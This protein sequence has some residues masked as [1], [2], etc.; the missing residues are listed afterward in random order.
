MYEQNKGFFI[1]W[2]KEG[3]KTPKP[4]M[5]YKDSEGN[6]TTNMPEPDEKDPWANGRRRKVEAPPEQDPVEPEQNDYS[7][8]IKALW[9]E[10]DPLQ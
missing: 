5:R 7:I 8:R 9:E 2:A 6:I 4:D 10:G 1:Q 3:Y